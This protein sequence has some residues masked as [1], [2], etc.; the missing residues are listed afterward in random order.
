[1]ILL[2]TT[3]T[4]FV[5]SVCEVEKFRAAILCCRAFGHNAKSPPS[6]SLAIPPD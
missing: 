5:R 1:V 3:L 6:E 4:L 2:G